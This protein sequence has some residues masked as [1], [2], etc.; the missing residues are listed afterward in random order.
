MQRL[1]MILVIVPLIALGEEFC[2]EEAGKMYDI[3]GKL[4]ETISLTESNKNN[5]AENRNRKSVDSCHMQINSFWKNKLN[6]GWVMLKKDPCYCSKVGSWILRQCINRYGYNWNSI[7]CYNT[8]HSLDDLPDN[9]KVSAVK[10]INRFYR[11][12]DN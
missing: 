12:L 6:G 11:I 9:R 7:V 1:I 3:S 10:Y 2:F 8:G 4:L 5:L